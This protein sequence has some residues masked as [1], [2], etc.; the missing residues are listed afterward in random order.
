MSDQHGQQITLVRIRNP[1]GN[2]HEWNGAWSDNSCEWQ[3]ID[4]VQRKEMGLVFAH[5]GEFWYVCLF[6]IFINL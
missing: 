2:E 6:P 1:W 3:A 4:D 5:D